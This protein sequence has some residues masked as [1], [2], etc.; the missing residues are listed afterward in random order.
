MK[1]KH[2]MLAVL[3]SMFLAFSFSASWASGK[4]EEKLDFNVYLDDK[5]IGHHRVQ[6]SRD[7]DKKSVLTTADFDVR[8][9]FIPV[10]SY[11]HESRENWRNGC[12]RTIQTA[13]DDNGDEYYVK[14]SRAN[15]GLAIETRE[16]SRTIDGCVRTF[17]YWDPQLL[18]S[19][20]LLN[21]Q[22]GKYEKVV[23][24][25]RGTGTLNVNDFTYQARQFSLDV[26][27]TTIDLW[28]TEDMRWLALETETSNGAR[29]RYLPEKLNMARVDES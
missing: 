26:E 10:Y 1:I 5:F 4:S 24:V 7:E 6:I 18:K 13:T 19:E 29:L 15:Q 9:M 14:T 20:R 22:T 16:G 21:T 2:N 28:Y 3:C 27:G 8:F 12:L 23:V 17:A 11:N 25:D